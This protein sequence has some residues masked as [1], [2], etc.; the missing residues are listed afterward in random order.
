M[1]DELTKKAAELEQTLRVLDEEN[2]LLA[3]RAED[4]LLL[5][6]ISESSEDAESGLEIL[7]NT[8]E[9]IS[10]LKSLPLATCARYHKGKLE[11]LVSY[12]HFASEEAANYQI[13]I[14]DALVATLDAKPQL[15]QYGKGIQ[16]GFAS[17]LFVPSHAVMIGFTSQA[18]SHGIFIFLDDGNDA[19][20]LEAMLPLLSRAVEM[21]ISKFDNAYLLQALKETNKNLESLVEMRTLDL[22]EANKQLRNEMQERKISQKALQ[23]SHLTLTTVLNSVDAMIYVTDLENGTVLFMNQR[24]Q[25][26]LGADYTGRNFQE[27]FDFDNNAEIA[28]YQKEHLDHDGKPTDPKVWQ[29]QSAKSGKWYVI[30]DRAVMWSDSR[31]VL[32]RIATDV[33]LFKDMEDKLQ[34]TQKME[35]IGTLAGGVAHDFNN[36]L[37]GI[38]GRA[39]LMLTTLAE[40][41]PAS[42][43]ARSIEE[44]VKSAADLTKQILGFARGGK[45]TVK[46]VDLNDL[47]TR[48]CE[49]FGRTRKELIITMNLKPAQLPAKIDESQ[50][51][52][53]LLNL[54]INGW[55]AMQGG[56]ELVIKTD[57]IYLHNEDALIHNVTPG[58]FCLISISD[59]G[60]GMDEATQKRVFD[61][62]FTTK[63]KERGTGLG[64]ASAYGI[65]NNHKGIITVASHLGEGSTFTVYLQ[66]STEKVHENAIADTDLASGTETILLVDDEE[67]IRDVGQKMLEQLG[68]TVMLAEDG[69]S[70]VS[71]F[72]KKAQDIDLVILDLI[73]PGMDGGETLEKLLEIQPTVTVL[74]SS[75][76]ARNDH[77]NAVM[78][79]GC[80]AFLQKPFSLS[81]LA[82]YVRKVLDTPTPQRN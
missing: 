63:E 10:I 35:A 67:M 82:E 33:T 52:Q 79:L 43:H 37:M 73:M 8:L 15:I 47:V 48:T 39:S 56:G 25:D 9:R 12:T 5:G 22:V 40:S 3:E 17:E 64:L 41:H 75:G 71:I 51:E 30:S 65:I 61:P 80:K 53:V 13:S 76:Y 2:R 69:E 21:I 28:Q 44:Y 59:S 19:E 34:H 16:C 49:M 74:L 60:I 18:I 70:A 26:E 68:Y 62:F 46:V 81:I 77:A 32:L 50:I 45:Y 54:L 57:R 29:S 36:L 14:D 38:Q 24:I 58:E 27:I 78:A 4:A 7:E 11:P 31:Y 72:R 55:Q 66:A 6:L 20:R 23:E 42:E 1:S